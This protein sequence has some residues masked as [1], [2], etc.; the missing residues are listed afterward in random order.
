MLSILLN[1]TAHI[2]NNSTGTRKT[3]NQ[4]MHT[5]TTTI[6]MT[7]VLGQSKIKLLRQLVFNLNKQLNHSVTLLKHN[8]QFPFLV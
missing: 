6:I 8:C 3:T 2:C 4:C 5:N 1:E 7:V